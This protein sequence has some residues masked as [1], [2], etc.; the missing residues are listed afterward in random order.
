[1]LKADGRAAVAV[2]SWAKDHA[3]FL[4]CARTAEQ[5]RRKGLNRPNRVLGGIGRSVLIPIKREPELGQADDRP[6]A[7]PV[8]AVARLAHRLPLREGR[9]QARRDREEAKGHL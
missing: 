9:R 6:L 3:L 7:A 2:D 4:E 5:E 1:M 8:E